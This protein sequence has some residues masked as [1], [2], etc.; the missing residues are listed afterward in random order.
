MPA[1]DIQP[2]PPSTPPSAS[3][4][5]ALQQGKPAPRWPFLLML[6]LVLMVLSLGWQSFQRSDPRE[7]Q[8]RHL[9]LA[10]QY[11]ASKNAGRLPDTLPEL[12]PTYYI[13]GG[14]EASLY[15]V[16]LWEL[17]QPGK[18]FE[19]T[20]L[21]NRPLLVEK[22]GDSA[23]QKLLLRGSGKLERVEASKEFPIAD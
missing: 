5:T 10:C 12:V 17:L 23:N 8:A 1:A 4:E 20:R 22:T 3:P 19:V 14:A 6:P 2:T 15:D 13:E 11:Y 7:S 18:S 16:S 9:Y 21:E